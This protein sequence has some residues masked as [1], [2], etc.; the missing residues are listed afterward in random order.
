M[1]RD[2]LAHLTKKN[3]TTPGRCAG[4]LG[5][6]AGINRFTQ[7]L[8]TSC[9]P[10][11][12]ARAGFIWSIILSFLIISPL[13]YASKEYKKLT[14]SASP[15]NSINS[16]GSRGEFWIEFRNPYDDAIWHNVKITGASSH[17]QVTIVPEIIKELPF[18]ELDV[19]VKLKLIKGVTGPGTLTLTAEADEFGP[20]AFL[21]MPV[22]AKADYGTK[23]PPAGTSIIEIDPMI[24]VRTYICIVGIIILMGFFIWRKIKLSSNKTT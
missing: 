4:S 11:L 20:T 21:T 3:D 7:P 19:C 15:A 18:T 1:I 12:Y 14:L 9:V 24:D 5:K 23:L 22:V 8:P 10:S 13:A 2:W 16:I 6:R 17:F